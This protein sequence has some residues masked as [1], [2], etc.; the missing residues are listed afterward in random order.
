MQKSWYKLDEC[1]QRDDYPDEYNQKMA[2]YAEICAHKK[3]YYFGFNYLS[4]IKEY[5]ETTNIAR[6]N[7]RQK[8]RMELEDMV[9]MY[10][11]DNNISEN[12]KIFVEKFFRSLKL[13]SAKSTCNM[14][15]WEI[16]KIFDNRKGFSPNKIDLYSLLRSNYECTPDLLGK[17]TNLCKKS[18]KKRA[19]KCAIN[20]LLDINNIEDDIDYENVDYDIGDILYGV[21]NNE[22]QLCDILL[23][24]CYK[25]NGNKEI[26]WNVCGE[27][28]VKRL[29]RT[30][31]LYYPAQD[32]CG[33][34]EVQGKKYTMRHFVF[35]GE[36]DEE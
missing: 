13:D 35:G 16:E 29:M 5:R 8:F 30:N 1:K 34:V 19:V 17:I 14:I 32:V 15:C 9:V 36:G 24:Y 21:C 11:N 20:F 4:L 23:D 22:E 25:Y 27:T 10:Q 33:E 2:L 12:H 18:E 3:P 7:A 26:L 6:T 31:E 28:I